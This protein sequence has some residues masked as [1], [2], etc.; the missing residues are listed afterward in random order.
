MNLFN[1]FFL[2]SYFQRAR[3]CDIGV[4]FFLYKKFHLNKFQTVRTCYMVEALSLQKKNDYGSDKSDIGKMG[5]GAEASPPFRQTGADGPGVGS[6]SRQ[7]RQDR[8]PQ[9]G[10]VESPASAVYRGNLFQAVQTGRAGNGQAAE[11]DYV[12]AGSQEET[13]ERE[14]RGTEE[15]EN[16]LLRHGGINIHT[17]KVLIQAPFLSG[18]REKRG[19]S[20]PKDGNAT[21]CPCS[22]G[23]HPH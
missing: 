11:A 3:R 7:T 16:L 18:Y 21:L 19:L 5:G 10:T 22:K 8:Q 13:A 4:S 15:A 23:L 12:R 1:C 17:G 6:E 14:E 20:Y 2:L 9:A